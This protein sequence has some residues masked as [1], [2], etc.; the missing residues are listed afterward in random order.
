MKQIVS[1]QVLRG[2][3]A[4]MVVFGHAQHHALVQSMK[5]GGTFERVHLL[6]WGAGV[7]IFF[8]ISGFIM[9]YASE[10]LFGRQGAATEFLGRRVARIVPLYWIFTALYVVVVTIGLAGTTKDVAGP[11]AILASF[12]FW[13]AY[14]AGRDIP[15]PVLELGWTLNY[16]M[17]F[18]LIFAAFVGLRRERAVMAVAVTLGALVVGGMVTQPSAAAPFFWTRPIVLE[19][20]IGMG[21]ALLVRNGVRL[22]GLARGVLLVGGVAILVVDPIDSAHQAMNWTTPNDL[23][24]VLGWGLPAALIVAAA[25]LGRQAGPSPLSKLGLLV[26]DASYVLYLSHPFVIVGI[27]KA[28][29]WGGLEGPSMLWPM[30]IVTVV[31]SCAVAVLIH[32]VLEKPLTRFVQGLLVRR[33]APDAPAALS[34]R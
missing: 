26:G 3:A 7:D 11:S 13:P 22:P 23:W 33:R 16:E 27:R 2:L 24:R 17:F 15:L 6:P 25:V 19:F 31:G 10:G 32:R 21:I 18:Y 20:G 5:I 30:V 4:L 12:A 14:A 9:V 1:V 8:V 29:Q 28:A 34:L